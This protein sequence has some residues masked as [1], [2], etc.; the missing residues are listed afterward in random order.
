M[1][2]YKI[3][4][5]CLTVFMVSRESIAQQPVI[6]AVEPFV[7]HSGQTISIIGQNFMNVTNVLLG[8]IQMRS[9]SVNATGDTIR[10]IVSSHAVTGAVSVVQPS[11]T[12]TATTT[13]TLLGCSGP[14]TPLQTI[15][16]SA[17]LISSRP[18]EVH[19]V[20]HQ[21]NIGLGLKV[22]AIGRGRDTTLIPFRM[23]RTMVSV[24]IP[25]FFVQEPGSLRLNLYGICQV[26]LSTT[27]TIQ[28]QNS[29]GT[30]LSEI[31]KERVFPNPVQESLTIETTFRRPQTLVLSLV[32]TLGQSVLHLQESVSAGSFTKTLS[33]SSIPPG[34]Y[35]LLLRSEEAFTT[36]HFTKLP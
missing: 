34:A 26:M 27:V 18:Q 20:S 12:T 1:R 9:F 33:T 32:S 28:A 21:F 19:F 3:T 2:F 6:T 29:V 24:T 23:S 13:F 5:L 8:S 25:T 14:W 30:A 11:G 17:L 15:V 10:V 7:A 4:L 22:T 36:H 16:P 35:F 31:S